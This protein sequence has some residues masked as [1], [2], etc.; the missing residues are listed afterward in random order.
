MICQSC[1]LYSVRDNKRSSL[2]ELERKLQLEIEIEL[3]EL[4]S[5]N[6]EKMLSRLLNTT[7]LQICKDLTTYKCILL[8]TAYEYF[9][10]NLETQV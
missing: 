4:K 6:V 7:F 2:Q 3:K 10:E 9:S 5:L 1:Y 8:S